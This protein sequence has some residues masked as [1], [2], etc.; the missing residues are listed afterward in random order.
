M[1]EPEYQTREVA[2]R[3]FA[4]EFNQATYTFTESDDER[5]PVYQLLPT[6]QAANRVFIVGTLS[7]VT[8]VGD[9]STYL[10]ARVVDPVGTFHVYAGEYQPDIVD[11]LNSLTPP[12]YVAVTGKPRT[13]ETDAGAVNVSIRPEVV[14]LVDTLTRKRWIVE[15]AELTLDRIDSFTNSDAPYPQ[16]ASTQYDAAIDDYREMVLDALESLSEDD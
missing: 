11:R 1:S 10:H 7:E 8:D 6:G 12:A 2:R 5:A 9:E 15:T 16:M 3:V 14:G 4:R 13:F